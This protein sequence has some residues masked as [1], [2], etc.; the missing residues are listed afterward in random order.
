[1]E[2]NKKVEFYSVLLLF[3]WLAKPKT[4]LNIMENIWG[5]LLLTKNGFDVWRLYLFYKKKGKGQYGMQ[6]IFFWRNTRKGG[7]MNNM[8]ANQASSFYIIN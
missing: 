7:R 3:L 4:M 5:L 6:A 2:H 8:G 1:M